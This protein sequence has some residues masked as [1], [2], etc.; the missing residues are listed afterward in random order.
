MID[1]KL[2]V[3]YKGK[4]YWLIETQM[5]V[6]IKLQNVNYRKRMLIRHR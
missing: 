6:I 1:F 4:A 3:L 2:K 5:P